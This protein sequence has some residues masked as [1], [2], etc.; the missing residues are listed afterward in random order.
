[1]PDEFS[2]FNA[3]IEHIEAKLIEVEILSD[4]QKNVKA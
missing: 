1:M 3:G 2:A 4:K